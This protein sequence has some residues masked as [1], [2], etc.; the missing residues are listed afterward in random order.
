ML[1]PSGCQLRKK[2]ALKSCRLY[3]ISTWL[4]YDTLTPYLDDMLLRGVTAEL[5]QVLSYDTITPY[6]DGMLFTRRD[7]GTVSSLSK[8]DFISFEKIDKNAAR[9]G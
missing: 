8:G 1:L 5:F 4:S 3:C 2:E 6:L 9:F 7:C